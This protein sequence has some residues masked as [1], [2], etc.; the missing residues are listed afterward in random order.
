M[1][2]LLESSREIVFEA[3]ANYKPYAIVA[4][5]SGGKDSMLAYQVARRMGVQIDF[6]MHGN[7]RTGIAQTTEW[8]RQ[9]AQGENARYIEADA[10]DAYEDYVL[11]KGFFG[12]GRQAHSFA[13]HTLKQKPFARAISRHIR[14]GQRGRTVLFLNGARSQ[15]S[16]N[17]AQNMPDPVRRDGKRQ[18]YWVNVCHDWSKV[19]RDDY[20]AE[21]K[22]PI[23]PVTT[24]LCRS[25]ECLCGT[26]QSKGD[27]LE[28]A[29]IY[30]DWGAWLT[31]LENRVFAA[32]HGWGWGESCDAMNPQLLEKNGQMRLFH[33]MCVSCE[34]KE[35]N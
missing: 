14:Q 17:R 22:A 23:N 29:A 8:V 24:Q 32:G 33:P 7:T 11:R 34:L 19:E 13:Y 12:R 1:N 4:M 10:G 20:L 28:A 2:Q 9:V 30:P 31:D 25:G 6:I 3:I 16:A 26:S 21:I 18:N 35:I 15:E 5:M 27:R